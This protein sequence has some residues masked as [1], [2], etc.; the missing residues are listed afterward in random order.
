[1]SSSMEFH[2]PSS[3]REKIL[4]RFSP[5]SL[6]VEM[7]RQAHMGACD[8]SGIHVFNSFQPKLVLLLAFVIYPSV[9]KYGKGRVEGEDICCF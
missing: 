3:A 6:P 8:P 9:G 2:S 5:T 1:M 7:A 4:H